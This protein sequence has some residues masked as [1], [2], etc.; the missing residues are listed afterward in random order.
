AS[1]LFG[2][3]R[4]AFTGATADHDGVFVRADGGTLFLD[5]IGEAPPEVQP[6]LLR[7]L[8]EGEVWPVGAA[9]ARSVSVRVG[10]AT[11]ADLSARIADGR[12]RAP[13]LHRLAGYVIHLPPLRE[14]RDDIPR[15]LVHFLRREL[16]A[17]GEPDHLAGEPE[18]G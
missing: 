10:A 18:G 9:R 2:H 1:H 6:A 7:A 15:L 11:D 17:A 14:R 5:E 8:E 3:A 4:G 13:L 16:A 12:F